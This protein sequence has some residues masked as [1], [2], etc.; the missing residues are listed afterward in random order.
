MEG[1]SNF[2]GV[3]DLYDL[4]ELVEPAHPQAT[5][6]A[7][8]ELVRLIR[9]LDRL[10]AW[11]QAVRETADK[12]VVVNVNLREEPAATLDTDEVDQMV[13][14]VENSTTDAGPQPD[15]TI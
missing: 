3:I 8:A 6:K 14:Q 7:R 10:K 5:A 2:V 11:Q 15:Y 4:L 9:E 1:M 12:T 13:Q